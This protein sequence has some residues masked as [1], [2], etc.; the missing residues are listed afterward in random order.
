MAF[1]TAFYAGRVYFR[2]FRG[3]TRMSPE[4]RSRVREPGG[5]SFWPLTA[6]AFLAVAGGWLGPSAGLNPFPVDPAA[7]NSLAN[8]L[9]SVFGSFPHV[10]APE[11]ERGHA[12]F[13]AVLSVVGFA[14]AARLHGRRRPEREAHR[15]VVGFRRVLASGFGIDALYRRVVVGPLRW[16]SE[17]V[18]DRGI[19]ARAIDGL[20]VEG[21]ARAVAALARGAL[22]RAHAGFLQGALFWMLL[23]TLAVAGYLVGA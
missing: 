18:L 5:T 20:L 19:D 7:S 22:R 9:G 8:H 21:S 15:V 14:L 6:L 4:A 12:A 23:G 1:L 3:V 17:R 11:T 2:S 16:F 10:A 13:V